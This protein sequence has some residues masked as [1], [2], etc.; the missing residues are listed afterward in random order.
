MASLHL[1]TVEHH[2]ENSTADIWNEVEL[3]SL[4]IMNNTRSTNLF[5]L[6]SSGWLQS[7]GDS[8]L[9][10]PLERRGGIVES[11]G[12]RVVIGGRS[13]AMTILELPGEQGRPPP[14]P[15]HAVWR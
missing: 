2:I 6:T 14:I 13:G 7:G 1:H 9:W 12:R 5:V 4:R 10:L 11:F 3:P 15:Y 8:L